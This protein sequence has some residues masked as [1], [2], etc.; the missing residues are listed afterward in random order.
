VKAIFHRTFHWRSRV[1]PGIG[2]GVNAS[3]EPQGPFPRE[4][5]EAA[6][7]Y[8]AAT[9]VPPRRKAKA[10]PTPRD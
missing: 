5:I 8:G 6:I 3:P 10:D 4:F 9:P 2:W 7:K 1:T